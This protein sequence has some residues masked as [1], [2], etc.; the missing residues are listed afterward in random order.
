M[1]W[2]KATLTWESGTAG[3]VRT[4]TAEV[5]AAE[6]PVLA[7]E[8]RGGFLRTRLDGTISHFNVDRIIAIDEIP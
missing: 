6:A 2:K 8:I 1:A 3:P 7:L 4:Q 5:E